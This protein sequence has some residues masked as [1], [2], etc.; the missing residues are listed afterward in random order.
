MKSF[1]AVFA[2]VLLLGAL[3]RAQ[4]ASSTAESQES[5]QSVAAAA[6]ASRA[7]VDIKKAK[8]ADI[9]QL[10]EVTHAGALATQTMDGM[11]G[12][13]RTLMANAFPPGEYRAKLVDLFFDKFHAK[14]DPQ[15]LLDIAVPVYDKYYSDDEVKQ[16][17]QLYATP[18]GQKMLTV[19]PKVV[20]ELQAA[21]QKWGE[22]LGRQS[23]M[24]VLAEHPEMEKALQE[25]QK[26]AQAAK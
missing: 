15:Q 17:I 1:A 22:E 20:A 24:E 6:K 18:L 23:M 12:N 9:R 11:E 14:R 25:A 2:T 21:G 7:Q 3:C 19:T 10:L 5:G 4:G 8:E 26:M 13:M 16:L